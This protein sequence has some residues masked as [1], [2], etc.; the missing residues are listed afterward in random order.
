MKGGGFGFHRS[1]FLCVALGSER[2][3]PVSVK[4]LCYRRVEPT[5][6]GRT[7]RVPLGIS[8]GR[9]CFRLEFPAQCREIQE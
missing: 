6:F 3:P 7:S 8:L 5:I 1:P 2:A 9:R 4:A